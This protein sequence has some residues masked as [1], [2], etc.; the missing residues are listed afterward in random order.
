MS[1]ENL[2]LDVDSEG[3]TF[4]FQR[5]DFAITTLV[6]KRVDSKPQII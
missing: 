4:Q 6:V 2:Q 5:E 3:G 1:E